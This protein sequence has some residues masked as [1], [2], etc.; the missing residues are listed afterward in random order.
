M[1]SAALPG[2]NLASAIMT[3]DLGQ[4]SGPLGTSVFSLIN[5]EIVAHLCVVKI[6]KLMRVMC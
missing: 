3:A 1:M 2:S 5:G 6:N 4:V